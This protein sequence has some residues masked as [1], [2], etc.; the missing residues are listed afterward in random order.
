MVNTKAWNV[1]MSTINGVSET[2]FI[3]YKDFAMKEPSLAKFKTS[4]TQEWVRRHQD[5]YSQTCFRD[6]KY[7]ITT[8]TKNGSTTIRLKKKHKA[9]LTV[10]FT[11]DGVVHGHGDS[12]F[13]WGLL[14]IPQMKHNASEE[15]MIQDGLRFNGQKAVLSNFHG[16]PIVYNDISYPSAE[17]CYQATKFRHLKYPQ[18]DIE[19][20]TKEKNAYDVKTFSKKAK[21]DR[22]WEMVK[23]DKMYDIVIARLEQSTLFRAHLQASEGRNLL[24]TVDD[25]DWGVGEGTGANAMGRLLEI[26]RRVAR[27]KYNVLPESGDIVQSWEDEVDS[28]SQPHLSQVSQM[29]A[30]QDLSSEHTQQKL[31]PP[32]APG[33]PDVADQPEE[34]PCITEN[35]AEADNQHN[36]TSPDAPKTTKTIPTT[37]KA[38]KTIPPKDA[39]KDQSMLRS[40][41]AA[42][43]LITSKI[44]GLASPLSTPQNT[45]LTQKLKLLEDSLVSI[46]DEIQELDSNQREHKKEANHR[47]DTIAH[48]VSALSK[49]VR[50]MQKELQ[51]MKG[52][53]QQTRTCVMP[54]KCWIADAAYGGGRASVFA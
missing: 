53:R 28:L 36:T 17:S 32:P 12:M 42:T 46:S 19:Y 50:E 24:H 2:L 39:E 38:T 27:A 47:M 34:S 13:T 14:H 37:P 5:F 48:T 35:V 6:N 4:Q 26:V 44:K 29:P 43:S 21:K 16:D 54:T 25:R 22:D 20:L 8:E 3:D 7:E 9:K 51:E 10:K 18:E 41:Q 33:S 49:D 45:S 40:V 30:T 15:P 1:D 52:E 11:A 23:L 31:S